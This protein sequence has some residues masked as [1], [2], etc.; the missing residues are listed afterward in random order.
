M[1]IL[2][3]DLWEHSLGNFS[4]GMLAWQFQ[5]RGFSS[6]FLQIWLGNFSVELSRGNFGNFGLG[7]FTWDPFVWNL[8]AGEPQWD[9]SLGELQLGR[10][11]EPPKVSW[12]NLDLN[13]HLPRLLR[14]E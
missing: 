2:S 7:T 12:G 1:L 6:G 11:G 14:T 10:L 8:S 13:V 9:P 3:L 4:L 5:F